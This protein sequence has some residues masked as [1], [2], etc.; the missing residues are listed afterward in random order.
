[1]PDKKQ[2]EHTYSIGY[3]RP[4]K[5]TQFKPGE[6]G[7]PKGRPKGTRPIGAV[8]QEIIG[9]KVTITENGKSRRLGVLE[10]ALRQ[11][12][13]DAVR[14]NPKALT[15]ML[16]LIDRYGDSPATKIK[17]GE[18]LAE[19]KIILAEYLQDSATPIPNSPSKKTGEEPDDE[20]D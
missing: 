1:M 11:L 13:N 3:R 16:S 4:P 18:M 9:R 15:L 2:R 6:S 20:N 14:G 17:L 19:D 8:L 12:V 10:V 7:Y 5:A